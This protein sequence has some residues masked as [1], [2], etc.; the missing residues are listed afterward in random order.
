MHLLSN[1]AAN[2]WDA[3]ERIGDDPRCDAR[4]RS[5]YREFKNRGCDEWMKEQA[6]ADE[7]GRMDDVDGVGAAVEPR[8]EC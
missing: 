1:D 8:P 5:G 7:D 2:S 6:D 3:H 4:E